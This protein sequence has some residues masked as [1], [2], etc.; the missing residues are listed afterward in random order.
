MLM[1]RYGEA[2]YLVDPY[3]FPARGRKH[4]AI[5]TAQFVCNK[6]DPYLFPA[7][8]RK[9]LVEFA[10]KILKQNLVDPYLFPAR[11]RKLQVWAPLR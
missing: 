5:R 10:G 2:A 6:V 8:G 11:G 7:R 1:L 3:L 4:E 9:Q